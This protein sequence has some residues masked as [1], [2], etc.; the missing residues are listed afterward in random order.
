[1]LPLP[2][3]VPG[4]FIVQH[5]HERYTHDP[6]S[7]WFRSVMADLFSVRDPHHVM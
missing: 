3:S 7:R 1:V 6:A 5:W 4:Y 2:F